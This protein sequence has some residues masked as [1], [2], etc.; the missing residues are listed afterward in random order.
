MALIFRGG[1]AHLQKVNLRKFIA[2][3]IQMRTLFFFFLINVVP[4]SVIAQE[5]K[6]L[7]GPSVLL[8]DELSKN[9][10]VDSRCFELRFYTVIPPESS[11]GFK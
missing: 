8:P 6:A 3:G 9:V 10:A 1:L 4:I 7:C 5:A 11:R 2:M